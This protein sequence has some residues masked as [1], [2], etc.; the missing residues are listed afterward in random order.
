MPCDAMNCF[1]I[2]DGPISCINASIPWQWSI[3]K[4]NCILDGDSSTEPSSATAIGPDATS[5]PEN[6][7]TDALDWQIE[8][9]LTVDLSNLADTV[10]EKD[11]EKRDLEVCIEILTILRDYSE[12]FYS[13]IFEMV[14]KTSVK[15]ILNQ[16]IRLKYIAVVESE[17]KLRKRFISITKKGID[18][19]LEWEN[20]R[21]EVIETEQIS[22]DEEIPKPKRILVDDAGSITIVEEDT[23]ESE[24]IIEERDS[25][26]VQEGKPILGKPESKDLLASAEKS[27]ETNDINLLP[28]FCKYSIIFA[29]TEK[30]GINAKEIISL[31]ELLE[32]VRTTKISDKLDFSLE[33]SLSTLIDIYPKG[34]AQMPMN[35][36]LGKKVLQITRYIVEGTKKMEISDEIR[37]KFIEKLDL[38]L[39]RKNRG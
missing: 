28:V 16:L 3:V 4:I 22:E 6:G 1:P 32:L 21:K 17:G 19:L 35:H 25:I 8:K 14:K 15:R 9:K 33:E 5:K 20:K 26:T 18:A 12:I 27:L 38:V 11:F 30:F 34:A 23:S 10:L 24:K 29:F 39:N 37:A 13:S 36:D 7:D 31:E 2:Y